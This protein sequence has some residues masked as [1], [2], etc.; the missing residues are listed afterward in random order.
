M[1]IR[2]V[3]NLL[4]NVKPSSLTTKHWTQSPILC[5]AEFYK[6][7][8]PST[9]MFYTVLLGQ[10]HGTS[11]TETICLFPHPLCL[12]VLEFPILLQDAFRKIQRNSQN[13][14]SGFPLYVFHFLSYQGPLITNC[15]NPYW[16]MTMFFAQKRKDSN[17]SH[18]T[19]SD[20]KHVKAH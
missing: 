20:N 5:A 12:D 15:P 18:T 14:F 10:S 17:N 6:G 1:I 13:L 8:C 11:W 7:C 3:R 2:T 4:Q 9:V 19:P 16:H